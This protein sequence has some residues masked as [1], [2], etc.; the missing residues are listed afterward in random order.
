MSALSD[1]VLAALEEYQEEL[2]AAEE[3]FRGRLAALTIEAPA[4]ELRS[5]ER[6][7]MVEADEDDDVETTE[8]AVIPAYIRATGP[9]PLPSRLSCAK[10]EREFTRP[11]ARAMHEKHCDG[12]GTQRVRPA[13]R[14]TF[15]CDR[16]PE[17]FATRELLETHRPTHPPVETP[18]YV[19]RGQAIAQTGE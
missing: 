14:E 10:C 7:D 13:R 8:P 9:P 18:K 12:T 1:R 11:N 15:L 2:A 3:R 16:C 19:G 4:A 6:A 5:L 17:G